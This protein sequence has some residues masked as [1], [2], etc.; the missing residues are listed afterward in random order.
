M[1]QSI[2]AEL[3]SASETFPLVLIPA[4][5]Q[6]WSQINL[7]QKLLLLLEHNG[8]HFVSLKYLKKINK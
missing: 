3:G 8:R 1:V 2:N 7:K 4:E 6:N 5:V